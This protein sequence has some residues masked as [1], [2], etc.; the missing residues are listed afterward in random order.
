[1]SSLTQDAT[2]SSDGLRVLGLAPKQVHT[3]L[4]AT[5]GVLKF[6][7]PEWGFPEEGIMQGAVGSAVAGLTNELPAAGFLVAEVP[8]WNPVTRWA[9][10]GEHPH[11]SKRGLRWFRGEWAGGEREGTSPR[12]LAGL[13]LPGRTESYVYRKLRCAGG[14][15][16]R[17]PRFSEEPLGGL[18][19]FTRAR[20]APCAG[21]P[22]P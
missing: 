5:E 11:P 9:E 17:F 8:G 1:M 6:P 16:N 18:P 3:A 20:R 15:V 19:A 7:Y 21:P 10:L 22:T 2:P 14:D 12:S 4:G 13:P